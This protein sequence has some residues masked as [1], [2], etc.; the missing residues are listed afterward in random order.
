M[1]VQVYYRGAM[2]KL[3]QV[4]APDVEHPNVA[5]EWVRAE[6]ADDIFAQMPVLGLIIGGQA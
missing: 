2:N 6:L 5:L 1:D 3:H 4:S